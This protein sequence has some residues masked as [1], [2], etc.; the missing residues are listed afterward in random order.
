LIFGTRF[1]AKNE[2][3]S[4]LEL[5]HFFYALHLAPKTITFE[6]R[7]THDNNASIIFHDIEN[8]FFFIYENYLDHSIQLS[9][10]AWNSSVHKKNFNKN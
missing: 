8:D 6:G 7:K 2:W 3:I 4:Y 5:T 9:D 10:N 1:Q